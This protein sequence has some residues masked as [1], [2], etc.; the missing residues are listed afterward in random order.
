MVIYKD[1]FDKMAAVRLL[2]IGHLKTLLVSFDQ[3]ISNV[4][5]TQ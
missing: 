2:F 1:R 3:F 4:N 5:R